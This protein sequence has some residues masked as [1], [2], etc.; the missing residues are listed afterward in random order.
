MLPRAWLRSV[1]MR[2]KVSA[3]RPISS[4]LS[5]GARTVMSPPATLAMVSERCSSGVRMAVFT[6][7]VMMPLITSSRAAPPR[8]E[9]S[10]M[11]RWVR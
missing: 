10:R 6:R 5:T 11:L 1:T 3:T 8:M 2:L 7:R 9:M 4:W